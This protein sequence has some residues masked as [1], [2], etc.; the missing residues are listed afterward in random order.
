M[1]DQKSYKISRKKKKRTKEKKSYYIMR[2]AKNK[3]GVYYSGPDPGSISLLPAIGCVLL[4]E[5]YIC[6]RTEF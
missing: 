4:L 6:E 5:F 2:A 1:I 3:Y